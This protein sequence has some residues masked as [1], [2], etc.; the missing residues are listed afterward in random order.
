M[1]TF[2]R[3]IHLYLGLLSGIVLSIICFTGAALVFENEAVQLIYP[4]RYRVEAGTEK[5]EIE[6]L[7]SELKKEIQEAKVTSV[8]VFEDPE[9]TLEINF[10]S[11]KTE[12]RE[13]NRQAFLNPYS[14]DLIGTGT[15]RNE[16]FQTMFGLHRWLLMGDT[17][18]LIVGI[19]TSI[20]LFILIT[21]IVLWW[22]KNKESLKKRLF[23]NWSGGWKRINHDLHISVGFY[24]ALFLFAF[25]FT[26]LA[27]SFKWFNDG[28][29]WVTGT[30]NKQM[31]PPSSHSSDSAKTISFDEVLAA[32]K[33][34]IPDSEFYTINKPKD[35][36]GVFSV[37]VF[38][39]TAAHERA[40]DQIF[41]DQYSGA[42]VGENL[43]ENRN[44]CQRVRSIFY[45]IHVG[46]IGGF[47]GRLIAFLVCIAGVTFPITGVVLW[48]NR[49]KR[50]QKFSD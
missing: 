16:F 29:Y 41:V 6:K 42:V 38:R 21:G 27:W 43:Y 25:A 46:S 15:S 33:S 40:T 1:K 39:E 12:S 11:G 45:P 24:S 48:L 49:L 10:Q 7:I 28:I 30:E 2:F 34:K 13:N 9:R 4:E 44:L 26:G 37:T 19:S 14:G 23:L 22:P 50:K 5:V 47:P 20:F 32:V 17:G 18:K 3:N 36:D 35:K 31:K 8:K